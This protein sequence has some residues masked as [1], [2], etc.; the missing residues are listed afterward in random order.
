MKKLADT[1][2]QNRRAGYMSTDVFY[3]GPKFAN[4]GR[5]SY[6]Y[7]YCVPHLH[8]DSAVQYMHLLRKNDIFRQNVISYRL[9]INNT[10]KSISIE[11]S[12]C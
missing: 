5:L 8:T 12:P 10:I 4:A 6:L 3:N 2:Q 9:V 1:V 7:Y 11:H